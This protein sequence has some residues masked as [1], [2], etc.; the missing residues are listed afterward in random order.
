MMNRKV[1]GK[2][3]DRSAR[4]RWRSF[5][6]S[7]KDLS[8][9]GN[10]FTRCDASSPAEMLGIRNS[11]LPREST[12]VLPLLSALFFLTEERCRPSLRHGGHA[13]S[14]FEVRVKQVF[15]T[16]AGR[17]TSL[18]ARRR[19]KSEL[20]CASCTR[21]TGL[22]T[23]ESRDV[24]W[25]PCLFCLL[26]RRSL[27]SR[28]QI[29]HDSLMVSNTRVG[30]SKRGCFFPI[31]GFRDWKKMLFYEIVGFENV[32]SHGLLWYLRQGDF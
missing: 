13:I 9:R 17:C 31:V 28:T 26:N 15:G 18:L 25:T 12:Y 8:A 22:R 23:L 16:V 3:A 32:T 7:S 6:L 19:H 1:V 10:W 11:R 2:M 5:D 14:F 4:N 29:E 24:A 20:P 21:I 30:N 27:G